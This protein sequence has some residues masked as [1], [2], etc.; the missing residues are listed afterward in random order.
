LSR[1]VCQI[2]DFAGFL[3]P[4]F[5]CLPRFFL[6]VGNVAIFVFELSYKAPEAKE[7][8]C[9]F[10]IL[11]FKG[12]SLPWLENASMPCNRKDISSFRLDKHLDFRFLVKRKST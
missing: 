4:F 7:L 9:S 12:I 6:V 11:K 5:L 1:F 8:A 2:D 10:L 3:V